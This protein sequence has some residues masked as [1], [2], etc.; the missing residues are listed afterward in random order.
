M[1]EMWL[2]LFVFSYGPAEFRLSD[3]GIGGWLL[4]DIVVNCVGIFVRQKDIGF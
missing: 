1:M 3:D 2:W 4:Q